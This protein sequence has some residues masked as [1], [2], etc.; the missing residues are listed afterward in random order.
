ME[1]VRLL[2]Q[3]YFLIN[4][5]ALGSYFYTRKVYL[6]QRMLN[7]IDAFGLTR[8]ISIAL[9]FGLIVLTRYRNNSSLKNFFITIIYYCK[10]LV[11][12]LVAIG[13]NFAALGVYIGLFVVLWFMVDLPKYTGPTK[14]IELS[15]P[16]FQSLFDPKSRVE[17]SANERYIF[18]VF[19]ANFSFNSILVD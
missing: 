1:I 11:M 4:L 14:M 13:G 6:N 16:T 2:T 7:M 19:Y 17:G 10:I 9:I 15:G 18:C 3:P 12:I 8:E 5:A